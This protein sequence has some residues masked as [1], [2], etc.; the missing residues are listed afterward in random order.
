MNHL[1]YT[2]GY[3]NEISPPPPFFLGEKEAC[4]G[5][6]VRNSPWPPFFVYFVYFVYFVCFVV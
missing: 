3:E 4:G 1:K 2:L 5:I 6:A